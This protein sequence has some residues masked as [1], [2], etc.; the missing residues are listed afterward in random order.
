MHREFIG[1]TI[2]VVLIFVLL[3]VTFGCLDMEPLTRLVVHKVN[4]LTFT[5]SLSTDNCWFYQ[6]CGSGFL[7]SGAGYGSESSIQVKRIQIQGFMTKNWK[8]IVEKNKIFF[9]IKYYNLHVQSLGLLNGRPSNRR[10]LQPS[11]E[12][13]QHF[14]KWNLITFFLFCGI[15]CPPGVP[16]N[17]DP[18]H[19]F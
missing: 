17:P 18:Q 15:F 1:G 2:Y 13:I 9:Y 16:L 5:Q 6:C 14:K 4:W 7:E 10:S 19:C 8:N 11:K 12:N 3:I